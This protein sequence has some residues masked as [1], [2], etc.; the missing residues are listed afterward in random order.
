MS[1][2]N[3][4]SVIVLVAIVAPL[5][6]VLYIALDWRNGGPPR[7]AGANANLEPG[8]R[9]GNW[10]PRLDS[11]GGNG[12]A[13]NV[14]AGNEQGE[15]GGN[16]EPKHNSP[17]STGEPNP[18]ERPS[19]LP[20]E[21]LPDLTHGLYVTPRWLEEV[22]PQISPEG[23]DENFISFVEPSALRLRQDGLYHPRSNYDDAVAI[24][25]HFRPDPPDGTNS[26]RK[27]IEWIEVRS[28]LTGQGWRLVPARI[29][30]AVWHRIHI[31]VPLVRRDILIVRAKQVEGGVGEAL[32]TRMGLGSGNLE[33]RQNVN[34]TG[35]VKLHLWPLDTLQS[36]SSCVARVTDAFGRPAAD[37]F[38]LYGGSV[39]GRT[40][41]TGW[42]EFKLPVGGQLPDVVTVWKA[43]HV[44]MFVERGEL[45]AANWDLR[46]ALKAHELLAVIPAAPVPEENL[47]RDPYSRILHAGSDL[48]PVPDDMAMDWESFLIALKGSYTDEIVDGIAF[49]EGRLDSKLG[50]PIGL[51]RTLGIGRRKHW[52]QTYGRWY[53]NR[54]QYNGGAYE[55]SLP[56]AGKFVL[57]LGEQEDGRHLTHA[58]FIDALNPDKVTGK[59]LVRPGY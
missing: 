21:Q 16:S 37:A 40:D 28:S 55:V 32:V 14:A 57:L 38:V 53:H 6:M 30:K 59:L 51:E 22:E 43:G 35:R 4:T 56:Y 26:S 44:P 24:T 3:V 8:G 45:E 2:R 18:P 31:V 5:S 42:C 34:N 41:A 49:T 15:P 33:Q 1:R 58:L 36:Y 50:F 29:K 54:W 52:P 23:Y 48:I 7:I 39:L 19:W 20:I 12:A 13:N 9:Q 17:A 11:G 47:V 27:P 10:L 46:L 25:A